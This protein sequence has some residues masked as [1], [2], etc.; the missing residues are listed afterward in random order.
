MFGTSE[1][2]AN[3]LRS[4]E[5]Q[6]KYWFEFVKLL[7]FFRVQKWK[8]KMFTKVT[9][10]SR[11]YSRLSAKTTIQTTIVC[12]VV[13]TKRLYKRLYKQKR[14]YKRLYKWL[15]Y[16]T[17]NSHW[18]ETS[19]KATVKTTIQN[20]TIK[21]IIKTT[22]YRNAA[23]IVVKILIVEKLAPNDCHFFRRF[24]KKTTIKTTKSFI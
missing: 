5:Y 8:K 19:V 2:G 21:A 3:L 22:I 15:Y 6:F 14:L 23:F 13:S 7:V 1:K 10:Y 12:R 9:I 11:S 24:T 20:T 16:T 18:F 4:V 17:T